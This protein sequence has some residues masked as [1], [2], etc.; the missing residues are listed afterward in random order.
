M[1]GRLGVLAAAGV[2]GPNVLAACGSDSDSSSGENGGGDSNALWFENWPAYIDE[3]TVDLF[4][5]AS[6]LDFRYTEGFNDNN[7]YFAKVQADLAAGR[8]IGPD[9]IAPTNW[10]A[11][12][13]IDLGWVQ[14]LPFGDIP[15]SSNLV[16]DLQE[17]GWDPTGEYSLPYQSGM[18]GIAYNIAETG[19]ELTSMADLFDPEFN[20][21]IGMLTEM[22][23]T[24]GLIL[25]GEGIDIS[26][27][28]SFD[29]AAPAFEKLEQAKN[30]GQIRRFT[31]NDYLNDLST[32]NFAA[33][34]G[35]SGDVVQLQRDNP[36]VRFVIPEEGGTAW[37]DAM[38]IPK[39]AENRDAAAKWMDFVYDP[40]QAAQITAWVQY[41]SPVVG[42]QE[43]LE[44]IDP[45][46]A[47]NPLLFPDD[48]TAARTYPFA[49]LTEEVEAEY[50][51]AFS[52]ITGA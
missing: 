4:T 42:V 40:V 47:N 32:G 49:Q 17:P 2:V 3:E 45:D 39:G 22:R 38:V 29:E 20:G 51:M 33:C 12:R 44:K 6:G 16:A 15:N 28:T 19:R 50:D 7:E 30:D 18:T 1:L 35:W 26:N 37:A 48:E 24:V 14:T 52:Q 46:L 31:G 25:L 43:E 10:L 23:D 34:V 27:L 8:S 21:K 41:V 5:E 11:A 36:S 9:I 13:L